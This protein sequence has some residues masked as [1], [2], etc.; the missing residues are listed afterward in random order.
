MLNYYG[1]NKDYSPKFL[2]TYN[3]QIYS[4]KTCDYK[5]SNANTYQMPEETPIAL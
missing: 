1:Q 3:Q 4:P 5:V 2:N